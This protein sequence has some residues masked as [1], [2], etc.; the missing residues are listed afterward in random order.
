VRAVAAPDSPQEVAA[1]LDV[2]AEALASPGDTRL[3]V[4]VG[5]LALVR[6][7]MGSLMQRFD[8]LLATARGEDPRLDLVVYAGDRSTAGPLW[9]DGVRCLVG[10]SSDTAELEAFDIADPQSLDGLGRCR[11]FPGGAL[12]QLATTPL[13]TIGDAP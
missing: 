5:D 2:V 3:V 7:E 13:E 4:V 11:Q 6:R 9:H 1:L 10:S 12:V 8:E